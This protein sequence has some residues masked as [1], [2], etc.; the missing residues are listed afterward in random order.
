MALRLFEK[1]QTRAI[2]LRQQAEELYA[3][4]KDAQLLRSV[5]GTPRRGQHTERKGGVGHDFWQ[6]RDFQSG[7]H[8]RAIDWKQSGKSDRLL[9]R[10][11][12]QETQQR[13]AV[14]LQNDPSMMFG[15]PSK[16]EC[17]A[18]IALTL[19]M[20]CARHHDPL[21]LCGAGTVAIDTLTG[22]LSEAAYK[23]RADDLAAEEIFLIGDFLDPLEKLQTLLQAVPGGRRVHLVQILDPA[24]LDLPFQGRVL[25]EHPGRMD[26]EEVLSVSG[27][28]AAYLERLNAHLEAVRT[29]AVTQ[30]W[31]YTLFRAGDDAF[32]PLLDI[33]QQGETA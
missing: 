33:L 32:P 20:L 31:T 14:W 28:R 25:F 27:I 19:A 2:A 24:E 11:K 21:K 29:V 5:T 4:L 17:G 8:A 18:V 22:I 23:P 6:Y 15:T 1:R 26:N 30:N 3:R 12:E 9:I 10:Q 7:D 16:Y 13:T